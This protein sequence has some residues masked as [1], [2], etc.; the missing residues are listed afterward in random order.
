VTIT[1]YL[2]Y[3]DPHTALYNADCRELLPMLTYRP[4][5]V[6]A[7]PPYGETSLAWDRWPE[8]WLDVVA[9]IT[10]S[11]WCFGSMRMFLQHADEFRTAGWKYSQDTVGTEA[12]DVHVVWEKHN[13]SSRATDR[14]RRVHEHATHWY[15]GPWS[16]VH[17]DTPRVVAEYARHS[18]SGD[19]TRSRNGTPHNGA[20]A[21]VDWTDDGTRLVRSVILR[22]SVRRSI[23]RTE[24]PIAVLD[25]L[26]RYACPPGGIVLDPFAGSGSTAVAARAL[27]MKTVLIEGDEAQCELIAKRLASTLDF[28]G[29]AS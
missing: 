12:E 11:L 18:R 2:Y 25:P 22:E 17:H 10:S 1:P 15:R 19:L 16:D 8:G 21:E 3:A 26:L 14:F 20:Y 4:D 23:H 13:G 6:I 7:D 28:D 29:V 9:G 24:K 27:G 5:C